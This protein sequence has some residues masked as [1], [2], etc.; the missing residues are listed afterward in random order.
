MLGTAAVADNKK[1]KGVNK[2][3]IIIPI[4]G[5][6]GALTLVICTYLLWRKCSARHKGIFAL[7]L[8]LS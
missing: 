3:F 2:S 8:F 1:K 6:I 7:F 5:G 4:V